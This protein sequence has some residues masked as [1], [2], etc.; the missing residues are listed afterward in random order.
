MSTLMFAKISRTTVKRVH[1]GLFT[2]SLADFNDQLNLISGKRSRPSNSKAEFENINPANGEIVG[3]FLLSTKQ[4]VDEAVA[5]ASNAYE[6]WKET[7]S[8]ERCRILRKAAD[9]LEKNKKEFA[10]METI[11][12]GFYFDS[13]QLKYVSLNIFCKIITIDKE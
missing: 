3:K 2:R 11:D 13:F 1:V 6:S 4:D 7:T 5:A 8:S 10:V 12:T 9:L